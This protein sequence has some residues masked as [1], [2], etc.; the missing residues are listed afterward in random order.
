MTME[1]NLRMKNKSNT[2]E[3]VK[4]FND[5][6]VKTRRKTISDRNITDEILDRIIMHV[7][8]VLEDVNDIHQKDLVEI[9]LPLNLS[10]KTIAKICNMLVSDAKATA[11][12]I[13]SLIRYIKGYTKEDNELINELLDKI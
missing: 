9:L 8:S 3:S 10:N 11:G 4:R 7:Y 13:A 1:M 12:S 5:T 2:I 6:V